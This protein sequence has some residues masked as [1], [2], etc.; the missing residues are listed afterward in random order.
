GSVLTVASA[1]EDGWIAANS[2]GGG[3]SVVKREHSAELVRLYKDV[4]PRG[5]VE[6]EARCDSQGDVHQIAAGR[7]LAGALH[8]RKRPGSVRADFRSGSAEAGDG[9]G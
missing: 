7:G 5:Y 3:G 1:G 8:T 9:C 2:G 6:R 4:G